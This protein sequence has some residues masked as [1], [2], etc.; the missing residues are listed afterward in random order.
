[1]VTEQ[2]AKDLLEIG[3]NFVQTLK[4]YLKKWIEKG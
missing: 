1:M 2:Q 4:N 3:Q